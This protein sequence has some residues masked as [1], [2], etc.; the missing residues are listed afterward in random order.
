MTR[1]VTVALLD[2]DLKATIKKFPLNSDGTRIE[3]VS[4]GKGHFLPAIDNDSFVAFP[5][6][7]LFW[8]YGHERLYFAMKW[9]KKCINFKTPEVFGPDPEQVINAAK[10]EIVSNFGKQKQDIHFL[11]YLQILILIG[12]ALKVFGVLA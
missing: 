11:T 5:K 3:I 4:G 12:I 6:K 1:K 8:T 7:F 10:A 9:A 2:K